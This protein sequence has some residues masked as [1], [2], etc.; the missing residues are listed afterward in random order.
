MSAFVGSVGTSTVT[1]YIEST[2]AFS[3]ARGPTLRGSRRFVVYRF[4]ALL[5]ALF[6]LGS[7]ELRRRVSPGHRDGVGVC[8]RDDDRQEI[9]WKADRRRLRVYYDYHDAYRLFDRGRNRVW[10]YFLRFDDDRFQAA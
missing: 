1:S 5:P 8:R 10:L 3:R 9:D 4:L 2:T 7:I 6:C